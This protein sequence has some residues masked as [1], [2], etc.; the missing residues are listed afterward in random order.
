VEYRL[1][2]KGAALVPVLDAIETWSHDW[3]SLA[4]VSASIEPPDA[5]PEHATQPGDSCQTA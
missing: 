3:I 5:A 1:T 2:D 4:E